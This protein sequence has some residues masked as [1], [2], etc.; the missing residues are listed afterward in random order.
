MQGGVPDEFK[1]SYLHG[2]FTGKW[3]RRFK[4]NNADEPVVGGGSQFHGAADMNLVFIATHPTLGG[5]YWV[6]GC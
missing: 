2:D 6:S 4:F 1:G 5:V 3:I